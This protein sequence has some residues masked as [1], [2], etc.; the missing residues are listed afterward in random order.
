[1]SPHS[2]PLPHTIGKVAA[3]ELALQ[4][5]T[6]LEDLASHT[7]AELLAIH[8][9]GPKTVRILGDA[10]HTLGL[11]FRAPDAPRVP[12]TSR[13]STPAATRPR[14]FGMRFGAVYDALVA[15]AV[16]KDRRAADVDAL[17]CW[18]T[19]YTPATLHAHV[20]GGIDVET[21]FRQAPAPHPNAHLITGVVCGVRV[22]EVTDPVMRDIRR[23]DKLVDE[24]AR[25]RSLEKIFRT[26]VP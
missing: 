11:A 4:G 25:G 6:T 13:T 8:G 15:K 9:V 3:R 5:V 12:K 21:F 19:G 17:I 18:L 7:E 22:E 2:S 10:L 26:D 14:I 24:L 1:M 23:L 16:R 20:A